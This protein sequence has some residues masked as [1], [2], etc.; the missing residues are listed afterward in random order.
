[1]MFSTVFHHLIV[2]L[3]TRIVTLSCASAIGAWISTYF[4]GGSKAR[5][6]LD[7][8][9]YMAGVVAVPM[10]PLAVL[11]GTMAM[12][13][14]GGDALS[15]NKFLFTGLTTGFLISMLVGRWRFGPGI[16]VESRLSILQIICATGA[17]ASITILGSIGAKMSLGESTLD[18]FPFYP[19]FED[20]IVV[21][22]WLAI[23]LFLL[24]LAAMVISFML[25]PKVERL[26]E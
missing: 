13:N 5:A 11:S 7:R 17:L 22:Q 12:S 24:G 1:M 8:T 19:S 4:V 3:A 21:N 15:Y 20:S 26:P 6:Y 18:I 25:G 16:W 14:P 9:A 23:V 2:G 10:L